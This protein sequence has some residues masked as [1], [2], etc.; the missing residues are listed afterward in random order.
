MVFNV[1][2]VEDVKKMVRFVVGNKDFITKNDFARVVHGLRRAYSSFSKNKIKC[3][4][5]LQ[6]NLKWK[7]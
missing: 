5:D 3:I 7:K 2:V 4:I 6:M 1:R